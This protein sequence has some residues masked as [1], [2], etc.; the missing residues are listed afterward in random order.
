M[1]AA[2]K[3]N[4]DMPNLARGGRSSEAATA[5]S[6]N[7]LGHGVFSFP[8]AGPVAGESN[9]KFEEKETGAHQEHIRNITE[10]HRE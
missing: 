10:V 3:G 8:R 2:T 1:A 7:W 5:V 6:N 4:T 9:D